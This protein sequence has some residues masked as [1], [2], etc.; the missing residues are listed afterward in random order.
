VKIVDDAFPLDGIQCFVDKGPRFRPLIA[1]PRFHRPIR[2]KVTSDLRLTP[3]SS[4]VLPPSSVL[5][6]R[7][8][9]PGQGC[10]AP[11]RI[12]SGRASLGLDLGPASGLSTNAE[13]GEGKNGGRRPNVPPDWIFMRTR[14]VDL[15][16]VALWKPGNLYVGL[17]LHFCLGSGDDGWSVR[18][19]EWNSK[20]IL[21]GRRDASDVTSRHWDESP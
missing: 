5:I 4:P 20:E 15:L 17:R 10:S 2:I 9:H 7:L 18:T 21:R 19:V 1:V 14:L 3:R 13:E 6:V 12:P 11:L 8:R 16:P